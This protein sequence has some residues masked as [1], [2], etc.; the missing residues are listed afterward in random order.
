M[1]K[2]NFSGPNSYGGSNF[3]EFTIDGFLWFIWFTL[4]MNGL[5]KTL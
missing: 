3:W 2:N 1:G 5:N 4:R